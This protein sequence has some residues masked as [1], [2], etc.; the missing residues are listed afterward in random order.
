LGSQSQP[1]NRLKQALTG[2]KEHG[3]GVF[4]YRTINNVTKGAD[5]TIFCILSQLERYKIRNDCYPEELYVQVD[6]GSENANKYC[7]A[8]ME[9][10]IAKRMVRV[11]HYTRLPTGHT[12]EDIDACFGHIKKILK[13][14]KIK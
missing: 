4:L 11:I 6:G 9:L 1:N 7:L 8:A 10:I 5:L 3:V 12:H 2:V 14:K 13:G